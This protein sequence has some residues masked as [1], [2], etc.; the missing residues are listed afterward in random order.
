MVIPAYN[1]A[2]HLVRILEPLQMLGS[3][4]E[5]LVV[6]DGSDDTTWSLLCRLPVQAWRT[7]GRE[8]QSRARNLA[9]R[10]AT[11]EYLVF[12][13]SDVLTSAATLAEM[14]AF[15]EARPELDGVFGCYADAR[16]AQESSVSRFRNLLHRYVHQCGAG[17]AGSFWAGMGAIRRETFLRHGGFDSDFDGIEDVE[18]GAR[19]CQTGGKFWLEPS[20]EGQHLKRWTLGS[21]I[22]TDIL[23]RAAP[24]TY[25]GWLG[26]TPRR[27]L[28]LSPVHALA[29]LLLLLGIFW[30]AAR[31]LY[32]LA[33]LRAYR[34]FGRSGGIRLALF[35]VLYLGIHHLCCLSG[36]ALGTF[37]YLAWRTTTRS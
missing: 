30:P 23:V 37:R 25:Y 7:Q 15:L 16:C 6:D 20:F 29:P 17:P 13:D 24:W 31:W 21:M 1:A 26:R 4:W 35:S 11:G 9:A 28:N 33:N 5:V 12:V 18:L 2:V 10:Q 8:G 3:Q 22:R 19:I 27:G 34:F 32:L 14:V 36:A